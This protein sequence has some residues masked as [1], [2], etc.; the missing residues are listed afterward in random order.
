MNQQTPTKVHSDAA[1]T[2]LHEKLGLCQWF[3]YEA[4]EDVVAV[5]EVMQ[6]LG[7]TH[8]RTG[9]SWAD[10]LRPKGEIWYDWQIQTLHDAGLELLLSVWHVPPSL[11]EGGTCASPPRRLQD[12]ADF[13]DQVISRYGDQLTALELWNEPNNRYKWNFVDFDPQW[14]KFGEMAGKAAYWAQHRGTTTVLGGM[15][16]VDH[17]WL[18]LMAS[19]GVLDYIDIVAIHGFPEMWWEN[20][21]NWEWYRTWHGWSAKVATIAAHAGGRP[22][23]ITE[24]GLATWDMATETVGRHELQLLMLERAIAAPVERLYW[25]S[26]IDLAPEREAIEGFHVDENEYHLG[27]VTHKGAKKPAYHWLQEALRNACRNEQQ[28]IP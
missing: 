2:A 1:P 17:T 18:Q 19:Y 8:L 27:L 5:V 6:D 14:A 28:A 23:W 12:Y 13:I 26:A 20:A 21:P 4:Y 22:I 16:P 15:I 24:T 11:A 7:L 3:H 9:I 10:F 25:Y